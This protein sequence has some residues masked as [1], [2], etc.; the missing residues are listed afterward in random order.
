MSRA[1]AHIDDDALTRSLAELDR[2]D[3]DGVDIRHGIERVVLGAASVFVGTGVGL[4]LI[5]EDGL[6]LRYVASSNEVARQL[7]LAQEQAGEGP[8]VDAFVC[9]A[10]VKTEELATESRWPALRAELRDQP[11]CAILGVPTRL[12]TPVG[13]LNLY[14][15]RPRAWDASEIAALEAYNALLEARLGGALIARA[16][17]EIVDQLQFAL[18]SRVV[19]ERAIGLLMGRDGLD[20]RAAFDELRQNARSSRRR[21]LTVAEELLAAHP[22]HALEGDGP[23]A[24]PDGYSAPG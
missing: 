1:V 23:Q 6:T 7:E 8:C 21:V 14:C 5:T 22:Q 24:E 10:N 20:N 19:I 9:D 4:M 12:G 16:Q 18:D 15:D 11:I 2:P 17:G 3:G 13:T